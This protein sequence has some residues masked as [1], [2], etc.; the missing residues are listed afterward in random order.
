MQVSVRDKRLKAL[1]K[2]PP[3]TSVPGMQPGVVV[4]IRVIISV[5]RAAVDLPAAGNA[6]PEWRLHQWSGKNAHWSI[7]VSGS[8]RLLF[9]YDKEAKA[10]GRMVYDDPH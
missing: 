2:M 8:T 5:L 10:I 1:D 3:P 6:H 4:K 9:D 7:D